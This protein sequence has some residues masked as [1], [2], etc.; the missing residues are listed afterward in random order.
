MRLKSLLK[1]WETASAGSRSLPATPKRK[2]KLVDG[3]RTTDG[4]FRSNNND[5]SFTKDRDYG[6]QNFLVQNF[7]AQNVIHPNLVPQN[8][9]HQ[10]YGVSQVSYRQCYTPVYHNIH[11][12]NISYASALQYQAL[13]PMYTYQAPQKQYPSYNQHGSPIKAFVNSKSAPATRN[14]SNYSPTQKYNGQNLVYATN[15]PTESILEQKKYT[16][17]DS[18]LCDIESQSID[19][20]V[21]PN[22]SFHHKYQ[23]YPEH[24]QTPP[25]TFSPSHKIY[26]SVANETPSYS[27]SHKTYSGPIKHPMYS[28]GELI[29][30]QIYNQQLQCQQ[31]REYQQYKQTREQMLLQQHVSLNRNQSGVH[32][33]SVQSSS[34][35]EMHRK[36]YE[37]T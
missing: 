24:N 32:I 7:P 17:N 6:A 33:Q 31:Q 34:K 10:A 15:N 20:Y 18:Q 13:S 27:P 16:S 25:I 4:R 1:D 36:Q 14:D 29:Q 21:T 26:G 22:Q 28:N 23:R 12:S 11:Q 37:M 35:T 3:S 19:S 8:A 2:P 30:Q 5:V 9:I